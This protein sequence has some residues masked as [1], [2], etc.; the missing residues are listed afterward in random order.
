MDVRARY[1]S[2][3]VKDFGENPA[4]T[5]KMFQWNFTLSLNDFGDT[6]LISLEFL[7]YRGY[8]FT[9][10]AVPLYKSFGITTANRA[11]LG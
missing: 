8:R 1:Y 10:S 6:R 4:Y 2:S 7:I 11:I 9:F 3:T 5:W